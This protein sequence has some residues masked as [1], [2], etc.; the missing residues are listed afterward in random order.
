MLKPIKG[1]P[2]RFLETGSGQI[3]NISEYREDD[4]Y[5]TIVIYS[6]TAELIT[7]GKQYVFFR[8]IERKLPIDTNFTQPSR[9]S[10]GEEMVVDRVGASIDLFMGE[11]S[12][13][14]DD[15]AKVVYNAHLRVNVN[16]LLLCEGPLVK[17]A[18]GYGVTGS[19]IYTSVD[20]GNLGI[21]VNIGVPSPA[22]VPKLVKTQTLTEK[23]EII[24]YLTFFSRQW[25]DWTHGSEI[26]TAMPEID[27][28]F[29]PVKCWIH[30]L[31][32]VAIN[33]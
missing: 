31:L 12:A 22:A 16:N 9:L 20:T 25:A 11:T 8:D 2:G 29:V 30:G 27:S 15:F 13:S 6:Y 10:M 7:A 19:G 21:L 17:F 23:H 4:K 28:N 3:L 33:K 1:Q 5:D 26:E 32:K 24:G 18:S 14:N